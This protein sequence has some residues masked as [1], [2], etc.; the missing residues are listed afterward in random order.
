M[1]MDLD[2]LVALVSD[3]LVAEPPAPV[4]EP[5][6]VVLEENGETFELELTDDLVDMIRARAETTGSRS[7][8][9][10]AK[11]PKRARA[12]AQTGPLLTPRRAKRLRSLR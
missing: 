7:Q 3:D 4:Q 2:E 6:V 11:R 9:R 8:R 1:T 5:N 10:R 12:K